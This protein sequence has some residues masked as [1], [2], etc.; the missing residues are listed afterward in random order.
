MILSTISWMGGKNPFLGIAYITVGSICFFLGIVLLIINH[1]YG[2]R[3]NS[4]DIPNWTAPVRF[5]VSACIA[6][7]LRTACW[8]EHTVIIGDGTAD[9]FQRVII[10]LLFTCC[11]VRVPVH[12]APSWLISSSLVCFE[13]FIYPHT[14]RF[15]FSSALPNAF[16]RMCVFLNAN[17]YIIFWNKSCWWM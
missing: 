1:K 8:C 4:A 11:P 2:N 6:D 10:Q 5:H 15:Y 7:L 13:S 14:V 3:S 17:V 16:W 9:E 12:L